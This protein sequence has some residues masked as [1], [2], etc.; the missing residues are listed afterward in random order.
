M[1]KAEI[2]QRLIGIGTAVDVVDAA[3]LEHI[4]RALFLAELISVG[5]KHVDSDHIGPVNNCLGCAMT[6][7]LKEL[8]ALDTARNMADAGQREPPQD[9]QARL[10]SFRNLTPFGQ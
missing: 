8:V 5:A 6:D 10:A 2:T 7:T 3:K 4:D 1:E 9:A